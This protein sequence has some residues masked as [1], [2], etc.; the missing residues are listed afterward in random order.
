MYV[1]KFADYA[2][3][4]TGMTIS[5]YESYIHDFVDDNNYG[6]TNYEPP[7]KII[8]NQQFE[9][10]RLFKKTISQTPTF[11]IFIT[12]GENFDEYETNNIVRKLSDTN[13]FVQFVG[14]GGIGDCSFNYLKKLDDLSGRKCDNTGFV[15]ATDLMK[16][17]D[18]ELYTMLLSQ[19]PEWLKDKGIN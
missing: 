9:K 18:I 19:Y 15:K 7:L 3:Q 2:K 5:N 6:G 4:C 13:V 10:K 11:V 16:F 14:I 12:D 1:V 8:Y 17:S